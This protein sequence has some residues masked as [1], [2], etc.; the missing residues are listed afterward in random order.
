[1]FKKI[2]SEIEIINSPCKATAES[3][4]FL[5][6]RRVSFGSSRIDVRGEVS[7]GWPTY[8]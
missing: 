1:M 2:K 6:V 7:F 4:S 5:A 8:G 3:V